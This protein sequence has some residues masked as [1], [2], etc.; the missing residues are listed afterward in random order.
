MRAA[1]RF[2]ASVADA[3]ISQLEGC[4]NS[5]RNGESGFR[6]SWRI[7]DLGGGDERFGRCRCGEVAASAPR[8]SSQTDI[9][10]DTRTLKKRLMRQQ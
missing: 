7:L 3:G 4:E 2:R 1:C 9:F 10:R 6:F 8:Q 5:R